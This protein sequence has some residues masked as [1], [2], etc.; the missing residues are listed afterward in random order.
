MSQSHGIYSPVLSDETTVPLVVD[1][2]AR[3]LGT[4]SCRDTL[5]LPPGGM[6][7]RM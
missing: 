2:V 6:A 1:L 5:F 7:V 4:F 3:L